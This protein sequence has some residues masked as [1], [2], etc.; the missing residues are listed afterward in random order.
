[1]EIEFPQYRI[2]EGSTHLYE[3]HSR[4]KVSEWSSVG[5]FY[6]LHEWEAVQ[7]PE[8]VRIQDMLQEEGAFKRISQAE[9][10]ERKT[11]LELHFTH[12]IF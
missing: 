7:Y 4:T 11:H 1:M 6:T 2:L 10:I 12:R 8:K 3:I 5:K 9:F